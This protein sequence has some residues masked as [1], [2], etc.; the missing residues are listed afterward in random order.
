MLVID[1]MNHI[2]LIQTEKQTKLDIKSKHV[3]DKNLEKQL[4]DYISTISI[5]KTLSDQDITINALQKDVID[6]EE[7]LWIQNTSP[8]DIASEYDQAIEDLENDKLMLFYIIASNYGLE[9]LIIL[10]RNIG[11]EMSKQYNFQK[12]HYDLQK[13]RYETCKKNKNFKQ[14]DR[15]YI[16]EHRQLNESHKQQWLDLNDQRNIVSELILLLN[17][18][19]QDIGFDEDED[20]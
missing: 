14:E 8:E 17:P 16:D 18:N 20:I 11:K 7:K 2:N 10:R 15:D 3:Y 12:E 9:N 6:L 1:V 19:D 5:M 13:Q 4:K